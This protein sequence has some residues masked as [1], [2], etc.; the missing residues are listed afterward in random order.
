M[1]AQLKYADRRN[2]A[3][4][5]IEGADERARGEVTLKDL[6]AGAEL[7]KSVESRAA[8]VRERAAQISVPRSEL[9][10]KVREILASR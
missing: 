6:I 10:A 2:A 4:A 1:K 3:V 9:V 8:W 5:V 7:A